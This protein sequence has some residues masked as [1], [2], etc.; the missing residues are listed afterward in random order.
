MTVN[1][2]SNKMQFALECIAL[3]AIN[4]FAYLSNNYVAAVAVDSAV[5][6]YH[7]ASQ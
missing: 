7:V 3:A 6:G 2:P 5:L 4:V 1:I